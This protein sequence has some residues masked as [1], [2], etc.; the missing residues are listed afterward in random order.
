M[1]HGH[2]I[3]YEEPLTRVQCIAGGQRSCR[4]HLG[5]TRGQKC[6][7]MPYGHQIWWEESLT[8]AQCIAG[9]K[10]HER[11]SWGQVGVNLCNNDPWP[12]NLVGKTHDQS[13]IHWWGQ[14][15]WR[16]SWGQVGVNLHNNALW[17]P[18]LVGRTHDQS[19]MHCWDQ[20]SCT[21]QAR[22]NQRSNSLEMPCGHQKLVERTPDQSVMHWWVKHLARISWGQPEVKLLRNA[23]W[24]P[25]VIR[26]QPAGNCL[27]MQRAIKCSQC[28][29]AL[30]SCRCSSFS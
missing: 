9:V 4:G 6:L 26:G 24:L 19:V 1:I 29:R 13:V 16:V 15:S 17:P 11:V 27:E 25:G 8:K 18:N 2:Q 7:E 3:W 12:P 10:G 28:Y 23:I 5:S 14:R 21:G 20:K 22:V 30:C